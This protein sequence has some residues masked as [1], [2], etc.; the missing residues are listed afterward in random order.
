VQ[1]IISNVIHLLEGAEAEHWQAERSG[2]KNSG[3]MSNLDS[4]NGLV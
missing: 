3:S 1:S 4:I 2:S